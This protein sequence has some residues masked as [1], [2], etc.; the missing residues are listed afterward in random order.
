MGSTTETSL[1]STS[2]V[3]LS[4]SLRRLII[5]TVIV[6]PQPAVPT[7]TR[8]LPSRRETDVTHGEVLAAVVGFRG[9]GQADHGPSPCGL[10]LIPVRGTGGAPARRG[11]I[12]GS[13]WAAGIY[14]GRPRI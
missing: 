11:T 5:S 2:T 9:V 7:R 8:S 13:D 1:P 14:V 6:L 12:D 3:P 4:G 10:R